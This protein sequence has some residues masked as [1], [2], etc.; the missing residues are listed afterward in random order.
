MV[1]RV[2]PELALQRRAAT[3]RQQ[4]RQIE[5]ERRFE[6]WA[7]VPDGPRTR[8]MR[9]ET[10]ALSQL[11]RE[12]FSEIHVAN[13]TTDT[14]FRVWRRPGLAASGAPD[15]VE[16]RLDRR[17][18]AR[19]SLARGRRQRRL[20]AWSDDE[21]LAALQEWAERHGRSP[22]SYEWIAG[23]P[24]RPGSLCVRRRF[25]SWDRAV[26][27]AGLRPNP[28]RQFRYWTDAE[29]LHAMKT[30]SKRRGRAPTAKDWSA[31]RH[32]GRAHGASHNT[33]AR[34]GLRSLLPGSA[35]TPRRP[36]WRTCNSPDPCRAGLLTVPRGCPLVAWR[37]TAKA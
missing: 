34:S 25:R 16:V 7:E 24:D 12:W 35:A 13:T 28:R 10:R 17:E 26:K 18:W 9:A 30:W 21:I 11:L 1:A 20:A 6:A 8:E 31:L 33:S 15:S 23:S 19:A 2:V 4:A 37:S 36:S 32:I 5:L 27:W 29:I 22:N 14:V 3:T